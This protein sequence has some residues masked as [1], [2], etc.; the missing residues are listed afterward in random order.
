MASITPC[1]TPSLPPT[2]A[3]GWES[4]S[5]DVSENIGS[6]QLC[7]ILEASQL[8]EE[9]IVAVRARVGLEG[10]KYTHNQYNHMGLKI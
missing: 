5:H 2:V 10:M 4:V 3:V 7:A 6:V 1:F 9:V 8:S